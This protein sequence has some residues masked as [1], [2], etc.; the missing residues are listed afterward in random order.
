MSAVCAEDVSC[1]AFTTWRSLACVPVLWS[2]FVSVGSCHVPV[3]GPCGVS[4]WPT[5]A[6]GPALRPRVHLTRPGCGTPAEQPRRVRGRPQGAACVRRGVGWRCLLCC[7]W[8][9][10][11][12]ML[13][14]GRSAASPAGCGRARGPAAASSG[15]RAPACRAGRLPTARAPCSPW[16]WSASAGV[17]FLGICFPSR[18]SSFGV[19]RCSQQ[20][21]NFLFLWNW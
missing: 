7:L 2:V 3:A 9:W 4:R 11:S 18:F 1:V 6:G 5:L 21:C 8:L 15:A 20:L 17:V 10:A 19:C 14:S 16:V 12:V 13:A